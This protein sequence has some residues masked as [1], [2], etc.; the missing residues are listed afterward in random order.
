MGFLSSNL[1]EDGSADFKTDIVDALLLMISKVPAARESGLFHLCEFI[2]DCEYPNL[3]TRILGFLGE[4]VP[5]VPQPSK[6]IRFIYNRLILE[7]ALVRASAVD[8]LA[9]IAMKCSALRKDVL[10][11]LRFGENDH[12]DEVRDRIGLYTSVLESCLKEQAGSAETGFPALVSSEMPFSIDAMYDNLLEHITSDRKDDAFSFDDLP[13]E[14][15]YKA[16]LKAQAALQTE[17]KKPGVPGVPAAPTKPGAAP[18]EQKAEQKAAATAELTRIVNEI[19][20]ADV[21]P[22]Q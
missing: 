17:K 3:C 21:G 11:L 12:D 19:V 22:A 8:A 2:E 6:Y 10:L 4:E 5:S 7:N 18:T 14:E 15:A 1:R 20:Q 9:K 13:S 16:S